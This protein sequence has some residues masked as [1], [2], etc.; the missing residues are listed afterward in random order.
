MCTLQVCSSVCS[1]A[2]WFRFRF[3]LTF[4]LRPS[5]CFRRERPTY[6]TS[7]HN[8]TDW[9]KNP[10]HAV[11]KPDHAVDAVGGESRPPSEIGPLVA[12][13]CTRSLDTM[14][15]SREF[16]PRL[17]SPCLGHPPS[18]VG[19]ESTLVTG[20]STTVQGS[21]RFNSFKKNE[22][23]SQHVDA[24]WSAPTAWS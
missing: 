11:G 17:S 6:D 19:G 12:N 22:G 16:A 2:L 10:D 18:G 1:V 5:S 13:A 7:M 20:C 23:I 8:V 4:K 24:H 15:L 14:C 3:V 9:A 21:G